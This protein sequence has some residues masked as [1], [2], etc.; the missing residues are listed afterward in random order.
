MSEILLKSLQDDDR[1]QFILDNQHELQENNEEIDEVYDEMD[2]MFRF[3]KVINNE[4]N[5]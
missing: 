5:D 3:K 2:G 4:S 1:E